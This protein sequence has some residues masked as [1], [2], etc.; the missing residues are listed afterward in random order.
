MITSSA[1]IISTQSGGVTTSGATAVAGQSVFFSG[2]QTISGGTVELDMAG[3]AGT[4]LGA[5]MNN[6]ATALPAAG[7]T[8]KGQNLTGALT[9]STAVTTNKAVVYTFCGQAI[10]QSAAIVLGH[11]NS[12]I[13]GCA[14]RPTVF[15]KAAN[16]DMIAATSSNNAIQNLTLA[17]VKGSFTGNCIFLN[18]AS[19]ATVSGNS[20]SACANDAIKSSGQGFNYIQDN[21]LLSWGFHGY[22]GVSSASDFIQ[23][24]NHFLGDGTATGSAI[25]STA[26]LFLQGNWITDSAAF[27]TIEASFLSNQGSMVGNEIIHTGGYSAVNAFQALQASDNILVGGGTHG[28]AVNGAGS[29]FSN[30]YIYTLSPSDGIT[31]GNQGTAIG[32][33][34]VLNIGAPSSNHCGI[35]ISG[36]TIGARSIGNQVIVLDT[37]NGD[38]NYG[39]CNTPSGTH[40][41]NILFSGDHVSA[42]L[43]GTAQAYGFFLNNAANLNTNW[44]V[45]VEDIGCVHLTGCLKRTDT[46]NN[47]T[48]YRNPQI[49]DAPLDAGT[50]STGDVFV[51]ENLVVT[52]ATLPSPAGNGSKVYCTDC[53]QAKPTANSG[54]GAFVVHEAGQWNG[55]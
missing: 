14:G 31:L 27:P 33:T 3:I 30:N 28:P 36:D 22:E 12:A 20:I 50:G 54:G 23:G 45:T 49:G 15:T 38:V 9:L 4:D 26:Y 41:L 46:Q 21:D 18:G 19:K 17:G 6:C 47:R 39:I 1:Q 5:K 16:I 11:A 52:F 8:C 2:A 40:N 32:N 44:L 7:G 25:I 34:V 53:T 55:L 37:N 24:G 35:N 48:L 51:L 13:V 29:H 42:T 43:G 10:S